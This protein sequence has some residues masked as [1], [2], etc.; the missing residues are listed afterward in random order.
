[1]TDMLF[2]ILSLSAFGSVLAGF[3][4][5]LKPLMRS[6][7]SKALAYYLW[8]AVL[9]RL[10]LPFGVRLLV[11]AGWLDGAAPAISDTITESSENIPGPT[12][13]APVS[14]APAQQDKQAATVPDSSAPAAAAAEVPTDNGGKT[15]TLASW[16]KSPAVWLVIWALGAALC[17][18]WH[19]FG[20]IRF[21]G[22]IRRTA[23]CPDADDL[24]LFRRFS[25]SGRVRF[26]QS[27]FVR[28]PML[29]GFINPT[30]VT[31]CAAYSKSG[32]AQFLR[33]ILMHELTHHRRKDMLY[34]WFALI[35]TSL[36]WFNPLMILVRR[37]ISRACELSCDEAVIRALDP[38][39][40]Q[41]YGQTLLSLAARQPFPMGILST[42]LCEEKALLK[43]R[44]LFIKNYKAK[45]HAALAL[46][47][48]LLLVF[49][50]CAAVSGVGKAPTPDADMAASAPPSPPDT[51]QAPASLQEDVTLFEKFG[52][53]AAIPNEI[54]DSLIIQIEPEGETDEGK[55][56]LFSVYEKRS[57]EAYQAVY[58]EGYAGY[59]FSIMRY[60]EA[61]YE[62]F[63]G[64]DGSGESFFAKDDTYYYCWFTPTDVQFYYEGAHE[65]DLGTDSDEWKAWRELNEKCEAIRDDFIARNNLNVYSDSEFR[66]KAYTYDSAHIFL[67]YYPYYAYNGSK[68]EVRTLVLSQPATKGDGGIWCVERWTDRH[69]YIYPYFPDAGGVPSREY[70]AALQA[71]CDKGMNTE[72]LVPEEAA[73]YFVKAYFGHDPA[74]PDSFERTENYAALF[75]QSTGDIHDYMPGLL[76]GEPVS[77]YE[78][79]PCLENLTYDSWSA[80]DETYG[81]DKNWWNFL[82]SALDEAAVSESQPHGPDQALRDYYIGKAFLASDAAY[83]EGL[84]T[85]V[86][87]QWAHDASLYS[88]YLSVHLDGDEMRTLRQYLTYEISYSGGL[89]GLYIPD[90]QRSICLDT[91]PVGFPF[92]CE[93][94]EESRESS[95]TESFGTVTVV[96]SDGLQV[97]YLNSGQGVYTVIT[98]RATKEAYAVAGVAV[99]DTEEYL[100]ENWPDQLNKLDTISYDDAAWFGS[101]YDAAYAYTPEES[102]KSVLLL[103]E[104]GAV[105]G[106]E[107][108]NGIDGAMY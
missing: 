41:H 105:S 90:S 14:I 98:L 21:T 11:P 10:C 83:A 39:Q 4:F 47:L 58:S 103:I 70:Y 5:L 99:G 42:T 59:I 40:K 46:S 37:E 94:T 22:L 80:F 61:R 67:S 73:L 102:T 84:S 100:L 48:A 53:T 92:A 101:G 30:V 27:A 44:L 107:L 7:V 69:G 8:L 106:I 20:Y 87:R 23:V 93:L 88:S 35:V 13:Q 57:Y 6:R 82:W 28:T 1:M 96:E 55:D 64:S 108:I 91:Y 56:M 43:E 19:I 63:L 9:L 45:T 76:A 104:D 2:T 31:P 25:K 72:W 97:T 29:L 75:E 36:H 71:D 78:L 26:I 49:T 89:F 24:A 51:S 16:L 65:G 74:T 66:D 3:M 62:Q 50:G 95:W 17:L 60:S 52:L 54:V 68:D 77:D 38:E 34:K 18:A 81:R 12:V 32:N 86:M 15:Q 85:I 33:D 79:L